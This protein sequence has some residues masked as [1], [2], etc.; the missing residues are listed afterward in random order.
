MSLSIVRYSYGF[1]M[2]FFEEIIGDIFLEYHWDVTRCSH[3]IWVQYGDRIDGYGRIQWGR[4]SLRNYH[5]PCIE[6]GSC[7]KVRSCEKPLVNIPQ[8]SRT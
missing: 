3:Q 2:C 4:F 5:A 1:I 6:V 8:M 7:E